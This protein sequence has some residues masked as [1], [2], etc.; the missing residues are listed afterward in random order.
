M[1]VFRVESVL[2]G[3]YKTGKKNQAAIASRIESMKGCISF[4]ENPPWTMT[5]RPAMLV[6]SIRA[7]RIL[8]DL[9]H[10]SAS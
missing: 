10:A 5:R 6:T 4:A 8:R 3:M 1:L 2:F 7:R 9:G